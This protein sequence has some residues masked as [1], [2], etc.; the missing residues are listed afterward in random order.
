MLVMEIHS[1]GVMGARGKTVVVVVMGDWKWEVKD[2]E[3]R[4]LTDKLIPEFARVTLFP[5]V[6]VVMCVQHGVVIVDAA[7]TVG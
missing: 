3:R 6:G 5:G 2:G 1:C 4:W 7:P